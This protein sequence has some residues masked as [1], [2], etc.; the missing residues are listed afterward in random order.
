MV[1]ASKGRIYVLYA[2]AD[3]LRVRASTD[4][5]TTWSAS[6]SPLEGIYGNAVVSADG[7]LHV[8]TVRGGPQGSFGSTEQAIEYV[9]SSDGGKTFTKP[10]TASAAGE[11]IPFFASNPSIAVDGKTVHVAYVR[12]TKDTAWDLVIASSSDAGKTWARTVLGCGTHL[13]PNLAIY[14]GVLHVAWYDTVGGG[15]F[16]HA[17]CRGG[18]CTVAG[19]IN[20]AP[21][22]ALSTERHGAK[23]I[24]E[25][26]SLLVDERRGVLHAVWTQPIAEGGHVVARIFHASAKL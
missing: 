25:Y 23:W 19:A 24:G 26:E 4:N 1:V 10:V 16:A 3:A 6:V 21:F 12:G 9:V 2:T 20:D 18:T 7:R 11:S 13:V 14:K 15:R 17:T 8:V 5:G 22:A